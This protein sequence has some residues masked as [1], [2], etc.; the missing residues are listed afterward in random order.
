MLRLY[1]VDAMLRQRCL[2]AAGLAVVAC[3]AVR[4]PGGAQ[5]ATD[6]PARLSDTEFWTLAEQLSEPAGRPI[7]REVT[8]CAV[9][10]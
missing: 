5:A 7:L 10:Q 6:I 9:A 1:H 2:F 4:P 8:S 3:F